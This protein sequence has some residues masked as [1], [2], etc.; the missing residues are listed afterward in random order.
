MPTPRIDLS[1][2]SALDKLIWF[3]GVGLGS[4]LSPK[5]P[6][7]AGSFAVL[8]L[9]P[10]WLSIGWIATLIVIVIMSVIGIYIC[11]RTAQIMQVHDDGRIVWDEFVGQSITLLPLVYLGMS[12]STTLFW[13]LLAF[14]LFRL[15]D[16]WKPFPIGWADQK[17]SGGLGIMLDDILAGLMAMLCLI[18]IGIGLMYLVFDGSN[19]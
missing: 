9:Y 7:T 6:G 10:L 16:I 11:G 2:T 4:G 18:G 3:L 8:L 13:L 5:A 17:V 15:F 19:F 1:N 14:I 12:T